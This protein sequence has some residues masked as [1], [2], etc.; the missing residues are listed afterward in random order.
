MHDDLCARCMFGAC[1]EC[2][3]LL[4][5]QIL[6]PN[7][8]VNTVLTPICTVDRSATCCT[9]LMWRWPAAAAGCPMPHQAYWRK[10]SPTCVAR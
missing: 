8:R 6:L 9:T 5:P 3:A 2:C 1:T 10:T 7:L 4:L